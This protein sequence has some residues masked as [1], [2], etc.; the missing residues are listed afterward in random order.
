M[1]NRLRG[2]NPCLERCGWREKE[3]TDGGEDEDASAAD[4]PLLF[5]VV[6]F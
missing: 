2:C 1:K 5:F 3:E 4:H 6:L